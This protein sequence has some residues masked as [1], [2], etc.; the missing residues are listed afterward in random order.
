MIAGFCFQHFMTIDTTP[1]WNVLH[2]TRVGADNFQLVASLELFD[3]ILG[4]YD[5]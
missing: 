1:C 3:F 2:D 5:G 4:T